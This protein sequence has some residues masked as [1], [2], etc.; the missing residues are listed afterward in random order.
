MLVDPDRAAGDRAGGEQSGAVALTAPA[1]TPMP[2]PETRSASADAAVGRRVE[3]AGQ[4]R[5]GG[6]RAGRGAQAHAGAVQVLARAAGGDAER[7]GDLLMRTTL[8][9]A[10]Q[11]RVALGGREGLDGGERL[12]QLL[13]QLD[14]VRR[15]DGTGVFHVQCRL[16]ALGRA[17]DVERRVVGDAVE[18]GL[19]C[20][21]LIGGSHGSVGVDER[22]LHRVFRTPRA[23]QP[24]AVALQRRSIAVDDCRKCRIVA[25]TSEGHEPVVV[26]EAQQRRAGQAGR[27]L[28]QAG[29]HPRR[30]MT[31]A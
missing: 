17:Q 3:D 13:A 26:L 10:Q 24:S 2:A 21:L 9:L 30:R 1:P 25:L 6:D 27:V 20:Q 15:L 23:Q 8:E 7:Q 4:D 11:Q 16:L 29:L 22:L 12:A 28:E 19:Q 31:P 14:D 5:V 18:P